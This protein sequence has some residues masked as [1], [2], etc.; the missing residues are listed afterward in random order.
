MTTTPT[1]TPAPQASTSRTADIAAF[2]AGGLA[3][4][5]GIAIGELMAGLVSGAP[6]LIIAIGDFVI[7]NQ[8]PGA[9]ELIVELFGTNNKL[10]LN[11]GITMTA[12]LIAGVLGVIGR[13][14]WVV[15]VA[16]FVVAGAAGL[17]AA[18]TRPLVEPVLAVVTIVLAIGVA[19]AAL[20]WMLGFTGPRWAAPA[21][22]EMMA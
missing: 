15:P 2:V 8:P 18:L 13:R 7:E 10:A 4:G 17:G 6:S 3:A 16:G 1:S 5:L 21:P 20:R 19:L 22:A 9:K 14:S 12:I 11:V